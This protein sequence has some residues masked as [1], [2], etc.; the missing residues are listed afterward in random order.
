MNEKGS[1]TV[2]EYK[3]SNGESSDVNPASNVDNGH[4]QRKLKARHLQMIALGGT[5]ATGLFLGSGSALARAGP[6]GALLG[7]IFIG[8]VVYSVMVSLG[9][10]ATYLPIPGSFT[11]YA[12][13]FVDPALGFAVGW[14]YWYAFAVTL[15]AEVTAAGI[16]ISYWD[17]TT[18]IA[19]WITVLTAA[20]IAIN[21]FGVRAYGESEFWL[22]AI[23]IVTIVGLLILGIVL[24]LGG[25]PNHDRLGFWYWQNP[26]PFVE[27]VATG[28][29]GK[30][31]GFW[32]VAIQASFSY[33]GTEIVAVTA[34]EAHNP[35]KNLP[36][37]ITR[38]FYRILLF[39]V[40]GVFIMGLLVP[41]NDPQLLNNIGTGTVK[42]APFVI[43]IQNAN[44]AALPSIINAVILTSAFS[45]GISHLYAGSRT[46][47]ALALNRQAPAFLALCSRQGLPYWSVIAT[48]VVGALAYLNVSSNAVVVFNWFVNITTIA[49]L[50]VWG[51]ICLSYIRFYQGLKS[52]G[53]SRDSLPYKSPYQ[54]FTAIYGLFWCS[55]I[56]F[57][58]GF[59]TF[60]PFNVSN[61]LT[62]YI[63]III[64]FGC[65]VGCKIWKRTEFVKASEMDLLTGRNEVDA[66]VY[67]EDEETPTTILGKMW[68]WIA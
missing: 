63:G 62:A 13:R 60:G 29:L 2:I 31:L 43:A 51:S 4:L 36:K 41:S 18:N 39:Y 14:N 45:S 27:Y 7:Y 54:P 11:I 47:H 12:A 8:T 37:A 24:D 28:S 33:N 34:A 50:F 32:S 66:L 9:E 48:S 61:F 56:I 55:V 3:E 53:I 1:I 23:K 67:D 26:G 35:R 44:I 15:P 20:C 25:G 64:F 16:V 68:S 6:V 17:S 38:V 19:V 49:S 52:Q 22:S 21:F 58:N 65:Y 57:F 10:M 30:F 46:L 42:A 5:I 59:D 40:G